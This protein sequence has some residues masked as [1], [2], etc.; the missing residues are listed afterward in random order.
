MNH[1]H[2]CHKV[3]AWVEEQYFQSNNRSP[4]RQ[5]A[6]ESTLRSYEPPIRKMLKMDHKECY[7]MSH[8]IK[9]GEN[10]REGNKE[11]ENKNP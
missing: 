1:L 4:Y 2:C 5:R 6:F 10:K 3:K 8:S 7:K 11:D 9:N